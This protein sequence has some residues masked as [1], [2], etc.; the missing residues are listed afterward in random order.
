ML[1]WPFSMTGTC[2]KVHQATRDEWSVGKM[3]DYPKNY[4]V[5]NNNSSPLLRLSQFHVKFQYS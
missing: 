1:L 3:K 4:Y 2:I 5:Q